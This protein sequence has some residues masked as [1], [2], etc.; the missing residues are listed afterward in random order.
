MPQFPSQ[1]WNAELEDIDARRA[2]AA[3][4]GGAG[5][6]ARTRELGMMN[7]R[8]RIDRLV[9]AGSFREF[10]ALAG[11]GRYGPSGDLESFT[12]SAHVIGLA[13]VGARKTV[14]ASDDFTLRG[15]SSEATV[16]EKWIYADRYA[17]EY[18]LP[19]VRLVHSA[20]GSVNLTQQLGF[21]KIPGYALLPSTQLL[22]LAPVVGIVLGPAAGLGAIRAC[23][24]H[25]SVMVRGQ[26]QVFAGGPP[27][28]K[29]ALGL[30]VGKE[31][32][33]GWGV[34]KTSG[35]INNSAATEAEALDQ[36]RRF[37]SFL[38]Q[39][40]FAQPPV[41]ACTDP[42]ARSEP[43]LNDAIPAERRKVFEPRK[44]LAAVFDRESVFEISPQFG[45]SLVTC[46]ARLDGHAVGVMINN[47]V[48]MGG[49]LTR[50]AAQ[51]M[52][53]FIDLCDTFHLPMVNLVD[54][55]GS[56]TGPDAEREG[57]LAAVLR[58]QAAMEQSSIPWIAI[59]IRRCFGLAGG[60]LSPWVGPGGMALPHRFAWPSAR[61]GSVP[62]EGGVAAAYRRELEAAADPEARR[63]ELETLF[64]KIGSPLRTAERFGVVDVIEPATTRPL[65]CDWVRDAYAVCATRLGVKLRGM[66]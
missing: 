14:V 3:R 9:D 55:P 40:V 33:G 17:H 6:L 29:Q 10:G 8:E 21:T 7:A 59:V 44:I 49:A 54:Q 66:R 20:G 39:H 48:V 4:M 46:L 38:P 60:M 64:H 24:S 57:T 15:G 23:S 2:T 26:A 53:R 50:A 58:A 65:L 22:M 62:V 61:W 35:V 56:M 41:V 43:S 30:T 63:L 47:P 11:K 45:G 5:N 18:R 28:V 37:L 27:V 16:A 42:A 19:L 36:A 13:Q 12:P 25:F 34:H 52:E 1:Q 32:L 51:K 31:E